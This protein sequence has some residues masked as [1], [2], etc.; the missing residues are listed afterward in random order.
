[1]DRAKY[2]SLLHLIILPLFVYIGIKKGFLPLNSRK[3]GDNKGDSAKKNNMG[4]I[5]KYIS[6][7]VFLGVVIFLVYRVLK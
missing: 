6:I 5:Y 3:K 2:V 1:M 7:R 4:E